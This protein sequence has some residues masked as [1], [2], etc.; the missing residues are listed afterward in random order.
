VLTIKN[1]RHWLDEWEYT[2]KIIVGSVRTVM[3]IQNAALSGAHVI[4]VPPQFFP[5]M[6]DHKYTRDT[7]RQF[8]SDAAK[9]A[10]EIAAR[11]VAAANGQ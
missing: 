8:N 4:T 2:S 3:D 10:Q 5:K 9:A 11:A 7:V 6:I 1:V